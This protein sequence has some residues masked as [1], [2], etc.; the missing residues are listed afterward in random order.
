MQDNIQGG[1]MN[2]GLLFEGLPPPLWVERLV[3]SF[4]R[5]SKR[6][7]TYGAAI[8]SHQL[9]CYIAGCQLITKS[10]ARVRP[11]M[12]ICTG[13]RAIWILVLQMKKL[14]DNGLDL[15]WQPRGRKKRCKRNEQWIY[16][17]D[18]GFCRR[19]CQ[20]WHL[21]RAFETPCGPLGPEGHSLTENTPFGGFSNGLLLKPPSGCCRIQIFGGLAAIFPGL[22]FAGL[23]YPMRYVG[24]SPGY[25]SH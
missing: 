1:A 17:A 5:P 18:S 19:T 6:L 21:P 10:F 15:T 7:Y 14:L 4:R 23:L 20:R 2:C 11:F 8:G 3:K 22:E 13:P 25:A 9:W 12:K 24:K 16:T